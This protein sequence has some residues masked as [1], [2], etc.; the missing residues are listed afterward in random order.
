MPDLDIP[1]PSASLEY[2]RSEVNHRAEVIR[3]R[4]RRRQQGGIA[5][6]LAVVLVASLA[7]IHL[8]RP[9]ARSSASSGPRRSPAHAAPGLARPK[10]SSAPGP[11]SAGFAPSQA[12]SGSVTTANGANGAGDATANGGREDIISGKPSGFVTTTGPDDTVLI[13]LTAPEGRWGRVIIG[14]SGR[15]VLTVVR[16]AQVG[17]VVHI[18]LR[19]HR[20]G[21]V[22]VTVPL[23]G[24]PAGAWHGTIVVKPVDG[25]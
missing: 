19:T 20:S 23:V 21:T 22:A 11:S 6:A 17:P 14:R 8:A 1:P 24:H 16:Q 3:V 15:T 7:T 13:V 2:F 5:V 9:A 10:A 18:D 12:A 25:G 4:R